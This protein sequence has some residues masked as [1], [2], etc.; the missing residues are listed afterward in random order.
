MN[1]RLLFQLVFSSFFVAACNNNGT[2]NSVTISP[3]YPTKLANLKFFITDKPLKDVAEVNVN[4]DHLELL[5]ERG[6]KQARIRIAENLGKINLLDLRN[7]VLLGVSDITIPE[8]VSVKQIRIILKESGHE[9]VH[10][11]HSICPLK[12]PSAQKSGVKILLKKPVTFEN[13]KSYAMVVDFDAEKSVVIGNTKCLLKPVLKLISATS[14][15]SKSVDENGNSSEAPDTLVDGSDGN[16]TGNDDGY[17]ITYPE[18]MTPVID[19][20]YDPIVSY[21]F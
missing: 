15:P 14:V 18:N 2:T 9:V 5:L 13:N 6:G 17:D 20:N 8:D 12:T 11:D 4:I 19:S 21:F 3:Y 10:D 1:Q 16:D 7:G